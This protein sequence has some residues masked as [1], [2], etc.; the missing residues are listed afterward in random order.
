MTEHPTDQVAPPAPSPIDCE[1]AVR[2]L[3][4]FLDGELDA[5]RAEE[6]EAH[7]AVCRRCPPHFAFARAFLGALAATRPA[8]DVP[9]ALR[10]RVLAALHAE[11]YSRGG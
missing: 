1:T 4:D 11:G 9:A 5:P 8:A 6:V 10:S 2:R 7:L 3:W